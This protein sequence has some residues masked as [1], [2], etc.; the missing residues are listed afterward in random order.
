VTAAAKRRIGR[1]ENA[2]LRDKVLRAAIDCYAEKGW[3]GFNFDV[4][5]T[6]AAVGRPAMYRRWSDRTVLL[7][8][9][10]REM[11]PG[12]AD[13]DLGALRPELIR[14]GMD[15]SAMMRGSRGLAG[16]RLMADAQV[17]PDLFARVTAEVSER[18]NDLVRRSVDRARQRA[19]IATDCTD[20]ISLLLFGAL[21]EWS[22]LA[23]SGRRSSPGQSDV[24]HLVDVILRGVKA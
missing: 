2:E 22:V 10:F 7:V 5:A 3:S 6:R 20:D 15:Y 24:E 9:A 8:D 1:P 4:V 14:L 23:A 12:L 18:R 11:T 16:T 13:E 17:Y 19:E 21:W